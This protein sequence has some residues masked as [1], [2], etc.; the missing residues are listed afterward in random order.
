M[1]GNEFLRLEFLDF[2]VKTFLEVRILFFRLEFC[3]L[4]YNSKFEV[5]I[6]NF[7]VRIHNLNINIT[8]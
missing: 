7:E 1:V 2:E 3:F 8:F 4:G 5:R 6:H